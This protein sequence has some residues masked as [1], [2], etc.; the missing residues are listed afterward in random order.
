MPTAQEAY[1]TTFDYKVDIGGIF[2]ANPLEAII[3]G[4]FVVLAI[5]HAKIFIDTFRMKEVEVMSSLVLVER[6]WDKTRTRAISAV[7]LTGAVSQFFDWG[8]DRGWFVVSQVNAVALKVLGS[9]TGVINYAH[10]TLRSVE[11]MKE[12]ER[13]AEMGARNRI[14]K[15]D[16]FDASWYSHFSSFVAN[17]TF[18]SYS[19]VQLV[20]VSLGIVI[21]SEITSMLLLAGITMYVVSYFFHLRDHS[22]LMKDRL[23]LLDPMAGA[24][25][26]PTYAYLAR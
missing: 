5:V 12:V 2:Q 7:N 3:A 18:M 9:V 14:C 26:R 23:R 19:G 8:V 6:E 10:Q 13:L 17:F 20:S 11:E 15:K 21:A 16:I 22:A 1:D 24:P 4:Y 25:D